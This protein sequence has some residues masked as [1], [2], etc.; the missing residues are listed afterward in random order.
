MFSRR[1]NGRRLASTAWWATS[2]T[3]LVGTLNDA[4]LNTVAS[5]AVLLREVAV[6][7]LCRRLTL[8]LLRAVV[9][10]LPADSAV[11]NN[12]QPQLAAATEFSPARGI[13]SSS[14]RPF[15]CAADVAARA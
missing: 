7:G 5:P 9:D 3:S 10:C 1:A 13:G 11:N 4:L 8:S 14:R 12:S 2:V 15:L 6:D